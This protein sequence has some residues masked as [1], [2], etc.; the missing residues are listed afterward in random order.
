MFPALQKKSDRMI[1]NLHLD[2]VVTAFFLVLVTAIVLVS[3]REWILLM[4]RH[5]PAI[6]RESEPVWLPDY[7]VA[8][9]TG[10]FGGVAGTAALTLALAKELSGEAHLERAHAAQSHECMCNHDS[11]TT[12]K[13][14][15]QL[16]VETTDQRFTGV[17]RCC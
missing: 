14:A 12:P 11:G 13:S 1:F 2:A 7:A 5:K 3:L 16:Y 8:E 15:G 9:A 6:L 10:K 4:S 17:R